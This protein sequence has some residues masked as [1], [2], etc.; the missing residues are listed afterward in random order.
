MLK[1]AQCVTCL[2]MG[3][4]EAAAFLFLSG[5]REVKRLAGRRLDLLSVSAAPRLYS[6]KPGPNPSGLH[7]RP[8]F[9]SVSLNTM[10]K[11][12]QDFHQ[13]QSLVEF[14]YVFFFFFFCRTG[15]ILQTGQTRT[16]DSTVLHR[17]DG[18]ESPWR[19][20]RH[21][22]TPAHTYASSFFIFKLYRTNT[23]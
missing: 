14:T 15:K 3:D 12:L 7:L 19:F 2:D 8:P 6:L 17:D 18:G 21:G 22:H 16:Q 4:Q 13:I 1:G 10:N 20:C 11:I 9:F 23:S 5:G